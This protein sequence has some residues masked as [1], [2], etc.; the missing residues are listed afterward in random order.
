MVNERRARGD[1]PWM[2]KRQNR[3][4][5]IQTYIGDRAIFDTNGQILLESLLIHPLSP[6]QHIQSEKSDWA[7]KCRGISTDS[8]VDSFSQSEARNQERG[9]GIPAAAFRDPPGC[10]PFY[11]TVGA[12]A[13]C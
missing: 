3:V 13:C 10:G 12:N 11:M 4:S 5:T 8:G 2:S 7:S 9:I 1:Q 6:R